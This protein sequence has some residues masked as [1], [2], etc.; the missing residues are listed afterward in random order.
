MHR[1]SRSM[2]RLRN[3]LEGPSECSSTHAKEQ[4]A[5]VPVSR[6]SELLHSSDQLRSDARF[7]KSRHG[8]CRQ[9]TTQRPRPALACKLLL[10]LCPNAGNA[11]ADPGNSEASRAD[12]QPS[13]IRQATSPRVATAGRAACCWLS[14]A[15]CMRTGLIS[16][17][18]YTLQKLYCR[19]DG[20]NGSSKHHYRSQGC[21][22]C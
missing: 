10:P 21:M 14:S 5:K 19:K 3:S 7:F 4:L 15:A 16:C 22:V 8:S 20:Q 17:W 18:Q 9:A 13:K 1:L 12:L 2:L 6:P 11:E